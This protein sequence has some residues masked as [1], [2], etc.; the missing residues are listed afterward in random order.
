M[1]DVLSLIAVSSDYVKGGSGGLVHSSDMITYPKDLVQVGDAYAKTNAAA[2]IGKHGYVYTDS[3]NFDL[4]GDFRAYDQ[5]I[6]DDPNS[7]VW[8]VMANVNITLGSLSDM[9]SKS[10]LSIAF[11][12]MATAYGTPEDPRLRF[13]CEGH[14]DP[15]LTGDTRFRVVLEIDQNASVNVIEQEITMGDGV[16]ADESPHGFS[17]RIPD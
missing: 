13:L 8:P 15:A 1:P 10:E 7:I 3:V 4:H 9:S 17:L 6:L 16:L 5:Q 11:K 14:Y 2:Y 12:A